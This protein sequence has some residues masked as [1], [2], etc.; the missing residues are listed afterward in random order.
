MLS[1]TDTIQMATHGAC[2]RGSTNLSEDIRKLF[3][4]AAGDLAFHVRTLE[5]EPAE[6]QHLFLA[7]L[8]WQAAHHCSHK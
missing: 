6:R 2:K 3:C 4:H 5:E 7:H 1:V 8:G